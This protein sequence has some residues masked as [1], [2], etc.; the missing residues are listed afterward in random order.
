MELISMWR[1]VV[2]DEGLRRNAD[3]VDDQSVAVL[4]MADR[5]PV[6]RWFH[7]LR[8]RHV[9]VDAASYRPALVCDHDLLRSLDEIERLDQRISYEARYTHRPAAFARA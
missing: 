2:V 3:G 8:M 9:K 6:P 5:L 7:I 4:V 1:A